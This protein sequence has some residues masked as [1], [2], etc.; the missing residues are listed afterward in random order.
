M[1]RLMLQA[2]RRD[3]SVASVEM[4]ALKIAASL[5]VGIAGGLWMFSPKT[6]QSWAACASRLCTRLSSS[7]SG[8]TPGAD[9]RHRVAAVRP[10]SHDCRRTEL[11]SLSPASVAKGSS[12]YASLDP[13]QQ[14]QQQRCSTIG[15]RTG[16]LSLTTIL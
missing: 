12:L 6:C 10:A 15:R 8:T 5:T 16:A 9:R 4:Y 11:S 2:C 14:Q 13:Q 7:S 1:C 3:S